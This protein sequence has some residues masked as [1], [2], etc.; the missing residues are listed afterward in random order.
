MD[1]SEFKKNFLLNILI[2]FSLL[3]GIIFTLFRLLTRKKTITSK[4][5]NKPNLDSL[6]IELE[7][8]T[9]ANKKTTTHFWVKDLDESLK[10][11]IEVINDELLELVGP[12]YSSIHGMNELYF[13]AK[14]TG[15]SDNSF[16]NIHTDSPFYPCDTYRFLV[17]IKPNDSVITIIP[18]DNYNNKL[19]KYEV[20]GFD[21]AKTFHYIKFD[22]TVQPDSRIVLKLHFAK[23]E[24][25]N[26]IT[27]KYATWTRDL[28]VNNK[29]EMGINGYLMLL[30]QFSTSYYIFLLAFYLIISYFYFCYKKSNKYLKY[31]L[32]TSIFISFSHLIWC[33]MFLFIDY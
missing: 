10:N 19:E 30:V 26:S 6:L 29:D 24:I 13:T 1:I 28:F 27:K 11:K 12:N 25:C 33:S 18:D 17:C 32:M 22:K 5:K 2:I 31:I 16:I 9:F 8:K 4:I 14:E 3:Y 21:Y 23:N 7:N 20:L 15:N